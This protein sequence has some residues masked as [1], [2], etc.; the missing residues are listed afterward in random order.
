MG[1]KS[2]KYLKFPATLFYY[3]DHSSELGAL[4]SDTQG[5]NFWY[6]INGVTLDNLLNCSKHHF[7]TCA[8]PQKL[9]RGLKETVVVKVHS[10][11]PGIKQAL[12]IYLLS[13]CYY[14]NAPN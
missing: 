12:K 9:C 10:I 7:S 14:Y 6:L 3:S 11:D 2:R 5:F 1:V 13:L 4:K 8:M